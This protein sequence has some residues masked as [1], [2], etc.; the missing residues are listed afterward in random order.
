MQFKLIRWALLRPVCSCP[1]FDEVF[2]V[3]SLIF[4]FSVILQDMYSFLPP[5]VRYN[6]CDINRCERICAVNHKSNFTIQL[7]ETHSFGRVFVP[8]PPFLFPTR[9]VR[10]SLSAVIVNAFLI[11]LNWIYRR[12]ARTWR[13]EW[14]LNCGASTANC[15]I[16]GRDVI[17]LYITASDACDCKVH[18]KSNNG[19]EN[20]NADTAVTT[21]GKSRAQ[22][23][24]MQSFATEM[25]CRCRRR[26]RNVPSFFVLSTGI[27]FVIGGLAKRCLF[28]FSAFIFRFCFGRQIPMKGN[29]SRMRSIVHRSFG[30]S[31]ACANIT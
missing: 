10:I 26:R 4:F 22:V 5:P 12:R 7:F 9:I 11:K 23:Y 30:S 21:K 13:D 27:A 24:W 15:A 19:H 29:F 18:R 6:C 16:C 14:H 20:A 2:H 3:F 1:I 31:Y 28:S 8:P 25:R 17:W